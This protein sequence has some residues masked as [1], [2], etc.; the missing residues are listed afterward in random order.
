MNKPPL[1]VMPKNI[2][3]LKRVHEIS[4]ALFEYSYHTEENY[5]LM[6]KWA[7][8]L[9]ERLSN[10]KFEK[11]YKGENM[12]NNEF[13]LVEGI[14]A[15]VIKGNISEVNIIEVGHNDKIVLKFNENIRLEVMQNITN[16]FLNK[17][18]SNDVK[19]KVIP[20]PHLVDIVILK[21]Q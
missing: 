12:M 10:L 14:Q 17:L 1:G 2:Y 16:E 4:R 15:D 5:D 8:E 21:L 19:D 7:E 20:L 11:E 6:I 13:K 3:E 9:V 18:R